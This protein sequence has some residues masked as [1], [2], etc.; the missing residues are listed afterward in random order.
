M[1]KKEMAMIEHSHSVA[2]A[3]IDKATETLKSIARNLGLSEDES[4]RTIMIVAV[5]SG[6]LMQFDMACEA[7]QTLKFERGIKTM[8][9]V[10]LLK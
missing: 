4:P 10:T 6:N 2:S 8:C 5:Q 1:T 3:Y 7:L 9:A